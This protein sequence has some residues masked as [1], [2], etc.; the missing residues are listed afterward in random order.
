MDYLERLLIRFNS[1]TITNEEHKTLTCLL[2]E[3][4]DNLRLERENE[5]A[6]IERDHWEDKGTELANDIGKALGFSVGEHSNT[7]CPLQN[8][9]DGLFEMGKSISESN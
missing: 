7:N 9:I 4:L 5:Q 8:A 3:K 2:V 1:G 6:M